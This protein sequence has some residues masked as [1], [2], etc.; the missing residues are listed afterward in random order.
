MYIDRIN[1]PTPQPAVVV[2]LDGTLLHAAPAAL[3]VRGQS[4]YSYMSGHALTTLQAISA[5]LPIVIATG[6]N[7]QSV[8]RLVAQTEGVRY[9][10]FVLEHGLIA[11]QQLDAG[12][13]QGTPWQPLARLLPTWR[14]L[15]G[16]ERCLGVI[17]PLDLINPQIVLQ[18]ALAASNLQG[19]IL[20]EGHKLFVCPTMPD[21]L[22]GL[23]AL[24][25][26]PHFA[27][28]NAQND[29]TVLSA[30]THAVTLSTAEAE[31]RAV[32]AARAGYCAP[33]SAH[34]ATEDMLRWVLN[35][36]R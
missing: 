34:A 14:H 6:R 19:T 35:H 32:I 21:K 18:Q 30:S 5:Y 16:Y 23:K 17:P 13:E 31:V 12:R 26:V 15:P 24:N 9:G 10:G 36:L 29:L 2:D 25:I 11:R 4:G 33:T 7:A 27:L 3:G 22:M 28:G 20:V 8:Q 1:H